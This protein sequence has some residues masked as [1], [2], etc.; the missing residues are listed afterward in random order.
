MPFPREAYIPNIL[1]QILYPQKPHVKTLSD[2]QLTYLILQDATINIPICLRIMY[3]DLIICTTPETNCV[4]TVCCRTSRGN[5]STSHFYVTLWA[6]L[7]TT[8][9]EPVGRAGARIAVLLLSRVRDFLVADSVS[10]VLG[11]CKEERIRPQR[12]GQMARTSPVQVLRGG[13]QKIIQPG[14]ACDV[15][16]PS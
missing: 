16:Q 4:Q 13:H 7:L 12:S 8:A 15:F 10:E 3:F 1:Y 11:N 2:A 6:P 5:L 9:T 14:D